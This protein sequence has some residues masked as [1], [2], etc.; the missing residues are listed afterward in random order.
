MYFTVRI[1]L[2]VL[3]ELTDRRRLLPLA[4]RTLF[5]RNFFRKLKNDDLAVLYKPS[6]EENRRFSA[7]SGKGIFIFDLPS[8][9]LSSKSTLYECSLDNF[10]SG[11]RSA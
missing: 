4:A 10:H 9:D 7:F 1:F 11:I 3:Y 2:P 6:R 5:F 8:F